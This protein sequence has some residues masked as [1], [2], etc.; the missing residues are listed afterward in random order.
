ML[1]QYTVQ[2]NCFKVGSAGCLAAD[3]FDEPTS[4]IRGPDDKAGQ[5]AIAALVPASAGVPTAAAAPV[6]AP[7]ADVKTEK[8]Q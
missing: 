2:T 1:L 3:L 5:A 4:G 6:P 8:K 7:Y